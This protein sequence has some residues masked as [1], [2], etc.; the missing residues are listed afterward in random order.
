MI[1]K[2]LVNSSIGTVAAESGA[3]HQRADRHD[4]R[5]GKCPTRA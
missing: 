4:R 2:L 3:H 5:A 1:L